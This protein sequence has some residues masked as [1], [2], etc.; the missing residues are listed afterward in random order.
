MDAK[1]DKVKA[2]RGIDTNKD[3]GFQ[4]RDIDRSALKKM[5]GESLTGGTKSGNEAGK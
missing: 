2:G 1:N 3:V 5:Y 4:L